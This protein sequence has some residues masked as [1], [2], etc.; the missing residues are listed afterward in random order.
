LGDGEGSFNPALLA[1]A[2]VLRKVDSLMLWLGIGAEEQLLL[3]WI[4]PL[5]NLIEYRS[6][7][8]VWGCATILRRHSLDLSSV[9][10]P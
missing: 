1:N 7:G 9:L 5:L 4:V 6:R 2:H 3:A 8:F 10:R